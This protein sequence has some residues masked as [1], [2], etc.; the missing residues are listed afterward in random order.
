MNDREK[1]RLYKLK[2][3]SYLIWNVVVPFIWQLLQLQ[4]VVVS[5]YG[6]DGNKITNKEN[7]LV[8]R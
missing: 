1:A 4:H 6:W 2:S 8:G 5:T 7:N 3:V